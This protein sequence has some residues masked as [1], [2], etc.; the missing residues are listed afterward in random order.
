[1]AFTRSPVR[2]R[3]GF[4]RAWWRDCYAPRLAFARASKAAGPAGPLPPLRHQPAPALQQVRGARITRFPRVYLLLAALGCSWVVPA[5]SLLISG[6]QV[7]AL[8]RSPAK[9][10]R[11]TTYGLPSNS[12]M[13]S[14]TTLATNRFGTRIDQPVHARCAF[15]RSHGRWFPQSAQSVRPEFLLHGLTPPGLR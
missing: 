3:S 14:T 10:T 6:L 13:P 15:F 9:P 5:R 8:P 12:L 2:S 7:R 1:M 4:D 11:S